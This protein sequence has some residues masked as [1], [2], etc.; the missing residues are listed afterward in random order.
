MDSP[1]KIKYS[2]TS[3]KNITTKN[4]TQRSCVGRNNVIKNCNV[5]I[6]DTYMVFADSQ[7]WTTVPATVALQPRQTCQYR[8]YQTNTKYTLCCHILQSPLYIIMCNISSSQSDKYTGKVYAYY[9]R[10]TK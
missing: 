10:T 6:R 2:L 5:R 8:Q 9:E 3:N 4:K 1:T 7:S